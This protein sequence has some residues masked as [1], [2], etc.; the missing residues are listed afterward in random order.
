MNIKIDNNLARIVKSNNVTN[1]FDQ[2]N[3]INIDPNSPEE[4]IRA[5]YQPENNNSFTTVLPLQPDAKAR[6]QEY[7]QFDTAVQPIVI[8]F[9][10]CDI[11]IQKERARA[12]ARQVNTPI[13]T[14]FSGNKSIHTYVWFNKFSS[15]AMEYKNGCE[16]FVNYL[17]SSMPDYFQSNN[18]TDESMIP[19]SRMF[20]AARYCRQAGGINTE[21]GKEQTFEELISIENCPPMNLSE[22]NGKVKI[23]NTVPPNMPIPGIGKTALSR[24]TLHFIAIGSKEGSRDDN[25]FKAAYDLHNCGYSKEE[26]LSMLN[27]GAE[28]CTPAFPVHE[29][30]VKIES[31]YSYE[32]INIVGKY[33]YEEKLSSPP[34]AFIE[35]STGLFHYLDEGEVY[36]AT[37]HILKDIFR[38][39]RTPLPDTF[40]ILKFKYDVRDPFQIDEG[41]RKFNLF[42][43]TKYMRLDKTEEKIEPKYEFPTIELLLK[44][45]IP[46]E[47]ERDYFM[48]WFSSAFNS[49]KKQMTSWVLKGRQGSGKNLFFSYVIKPLFGDKQAIKVEDEDLKRPF[50]GYLKNVCF[51]CFNEVANNNTDRNS[52][53]SKIKAIVSDSETMINE[54]NIKAYTIQNHVNCIFFSNEN[55]PLL[56]ESDDR[57]FNIVETG[58]EAY[59]S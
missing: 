6:K 54:K 15:N 10:K 33:T 1:T 50:N 2:L 31:A 59:G 8:E 47:D 24:A 30:E 20:D 36:P 35:Q 19:D 58:G 25:C 45:L 53:N 46:N 43:A 5:T 12:L 13:Y 23:Y 51:I 17:A 39:L 55:V 4:I 16:Q 9:D 57:R 22:L 44:N 56:V 21:T 48:N 52:L 37:K 49:R 34:Y 38:G 27:E 11:A 32:I 7:V 40:P 28:K 41:G 14:V 42:N 29:V 18:G 26:A 3:F